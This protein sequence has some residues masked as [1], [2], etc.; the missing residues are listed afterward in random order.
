MEQLESARRVAGMIKARRVIDLLVKP[1]PGFR[2]ETSRMILKV[3]VFHT[4]WTN[5]ASLPW[6]LFNCGRVD[7]VCYTKS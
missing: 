3:V 2:N 5:S 6:V 7:V 1:L 4:E